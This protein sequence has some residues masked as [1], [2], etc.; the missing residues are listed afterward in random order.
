MCHLSPPARG[1]F[2]RKN[3]RIP[4]SMFDVRCWTFIGMV[5]SALRGGFIKPP[6]LRVVGD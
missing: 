4:Y 1:G 3:G 5:F 6:A 2:N